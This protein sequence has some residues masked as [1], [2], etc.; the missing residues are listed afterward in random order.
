M[1]Y[2]NTLK[3]LFNHP[4]KYPMF[5]VTKL[6]YIFLHMLLLSIILILPNTIQYIQ[7]TQHLSTLVHEHVEEIP[8]FKIKDNNMDLTQNKTIQL[9][10]AQSIVFTQ[11]N[12]Y[13]MTDKQ[14]VIFKPEHIE[15]SNYND[16]TN[17]SYGSLSSIIQNKQ[18]LISFIGTI[19]ASKYFFLAII[20]LFLLF[21]QFISISFKIS[22][23][24]FISH[25]ISKCLN[26]KTRFMTWL[27]MITFVL[28]LPTLVLLLGIVTSNTLLMIL[29][30]CIIIIAILTLINYLPKG[31]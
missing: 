22:I 10:D 19:N 24:A 21:I 6:R 3:R 28:T 2:I 14:L 31:K 13:K 27:K 11:S 16:H 29:S 23:L 9:N 26:K 17:I 4:S 15:L 12:H 7:V 18:D 8:E 20:I 5:R 1:Q 30:W 25:M